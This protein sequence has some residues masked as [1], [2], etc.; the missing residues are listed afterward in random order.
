ME[1]WR[2]DESYKKPPNQLPFSIR[3]PLLAT[4]INVAALFICPAKFVF[5]EEPPK[6]QI[7][8]INLDKR[9][10][11]FLG[12]DHHLRSLG[13]RPA[14]RFTDEVNSMETFRVLA[15]PGNASAVNLVRQ[16]RLLVETEPK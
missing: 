2:A 15:R 5:R 6:S 7:E 4:L 9:S 16:S 14:G 13:M 11:K 12:N 3:P 8:L 10:P 1:C